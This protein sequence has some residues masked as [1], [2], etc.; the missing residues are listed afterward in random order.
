VLDQRQVK[1]HADRN[2]RP[3]VLTSRSWVLCSPVPMGYSPSLRLPSNAFCL[4]GG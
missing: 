3:S 4:P 1:A 2:N